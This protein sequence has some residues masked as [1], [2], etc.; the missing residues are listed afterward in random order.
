MQQTNKDLIISCNNS[1]QDSL[2][3]VCIVLNNAESL[4]VHKQARAVRG[5]FHPGNSKKKRHFKKLIIYKSLQ[6]RPSGFKRGIE[7]EFF[8]LQVTTG[9]QHDTFFGT[10][11]WVWLYIVENFTGRIQSYYK[12][13]WRFL[14]NGGL[15]SS[16]YLLLSEIRYLPASYSAFKHC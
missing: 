12:C 7:H 10:R 9:L 6:L 15:L 4:H 11:A 8:A 2:C 14:E 16:I 1:E 5:L 13:T 3:V